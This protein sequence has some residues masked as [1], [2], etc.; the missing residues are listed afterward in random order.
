MKNR[1]LIEGLAT[2]IIGV[3]IL[4]VALYMWVAQKATQNECYLMGGMGIMFLRAKSSLIG[5]GP[6]KEN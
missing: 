6:K 2:T 5:L 3:V 1:L 4:G